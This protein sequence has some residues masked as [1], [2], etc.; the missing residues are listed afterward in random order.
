MKCYYVKCCSMKAAKKSTFRGITLGEGGLGLGEIEGYKVVEVGC[1]KRF[2]V[3]EGWDDIEGFNIGRW[4]R[5]RV[6]PLWRG[7]EEGG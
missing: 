3:E 1:R 7:L 4:G 2:G 6:R 5:R